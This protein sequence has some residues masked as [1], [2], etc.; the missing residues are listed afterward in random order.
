MNVLQCMYLNYLG[1]L[2]GTAR[3][4]HMQLYRN[5]AIGTITSLEAGN[6]GKIKYFY[7]R[8]LRTDIV[9]V[10]VSVRACVANKRI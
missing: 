4:W 8:K 1:H 6:Y 2:N 7:P 5:V 10:K 9:Y 3:R